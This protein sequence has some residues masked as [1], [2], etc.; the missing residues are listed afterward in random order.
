M[1]PLD[2]LAGFFGGALLMNALPH[3]ASGAMGRKFPSPFASPP[4]RGLSSPT[5]NMLWGMGNL[6]AA[7]G[8]LW[9]I[10][11][12]DPGRGAQMAP[13]ALGVLLMGLFHARHFGGLNG[14]NGPGPA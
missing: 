3:I 4:G 1:H 10:A 14:G 13:L 2:L 9:Q 5:V 12:I 11:R 7:Y 6:A 8:L